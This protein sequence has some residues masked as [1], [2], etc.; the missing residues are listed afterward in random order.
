MALVRS[1][2]GQSHVIAKKLRKVAGI[3]KGQ[4]GPSS[5]VPR[6]TREQER[7]RRYMDAGVSADLPPTIVMKLDPQ[8]PPIPYAEAASRQP[9]RK[10]VTEDTAHMCDV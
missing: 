3:G 9:K 8:G 5:N 10:G 4:P 1:R 2:V 7:D 6:E